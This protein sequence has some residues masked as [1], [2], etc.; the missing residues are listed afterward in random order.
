MECIA[1]AALKARVAGDEE[2]SS[3]E[4]EAAERDTNTDEG[5]LPVGEK[6]ALRTYS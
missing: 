3:G 6:E 2:E 4:D 5:A 1:W